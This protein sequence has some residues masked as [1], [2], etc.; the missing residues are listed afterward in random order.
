MI[1][2]KINY[3]HSNPIRAGLTSTGAEYPWSSFRSI[4]KLDDDP[5]IGV[6]TDWWWPGD[7][8]KITAHLRAVDERLELEF[9][10]ERQRKLNAAGASPPS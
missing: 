1:W 3:I 10:A 8:E 5:R 9:L 7:V 6:D 4:Y 2:Q